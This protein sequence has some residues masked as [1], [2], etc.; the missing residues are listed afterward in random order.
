MTD[1]RDR[2]RD[3]VEMSA[4]PIPANSVLRHTRPPRDWGVWKGAVTAGLVAL[5]VGGIT[6]AIDIGSDGEAPVAGSTD[7][8]PTTSEEVST[9]AATV[10]EPEL[11]QT[12]FV[13]WTMHAVG[14][15]LYVT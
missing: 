10:G 7:I 6:F 11:V 12:P 2:I 5:L 13:V 1:L 3:L 8:T 4:P 15:D 9:A 14:T